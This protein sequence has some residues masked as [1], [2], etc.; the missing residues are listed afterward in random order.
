MVLQ[1]DKPDTIWGW[2]EQPGDKVTVQMGDTTATG[3]AQADRRWEVKIK[4]QPPATLHSQITGRETVELHNVLVATS[5][6][7]PASPICSL[8][9][10]TRIGDEGAPGKKI[11]N[12]E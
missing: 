7:A 12:R 2:S 11:G 4:P 9:P 8:S 10:A 6:S 3:V 1:R 5:G